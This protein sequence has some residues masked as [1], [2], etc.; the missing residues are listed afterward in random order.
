M[1]VDASEMIADHLAYFQGFDHV[2]LYYDNLA[3]P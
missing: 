1:S 3:R 2:K